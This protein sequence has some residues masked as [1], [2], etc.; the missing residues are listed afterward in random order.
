MSS[1]LAGVELS[2]M[3]TASGSTEM[4]ALSKVP[5]FWLKHTH[6]G[7]IPNPK[8]SVHDEIMRLAASK[9]WSDNTTR[10]RRKEALASEIEFYGGGKD[11]LER[12]QKLCIE[13][14]VAEPGDVPRSISACKKVGPSSRGEAPS[15]IMS[16]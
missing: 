9:G 13:V 10:K 11:R 16:N 8:A 6:R 7:F 12:W 14:D 5:D 4:S 1:T 3:D 15:M 2:D